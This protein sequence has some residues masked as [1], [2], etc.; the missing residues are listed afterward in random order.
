MIYDDTLYPFEISVS[1]K[2]LPNGLISIDYPKEGNNY[3]I[4]FLALAPKFDIVAS[5]LEN[6]T[7]INHIN[8]QPFIV[9]SILY[10][11]IFSKAI[12]VIDFVDY[13]KLNQI[14]VEKSS[15]NNINYNLIKL[16][17]KEWHKSVL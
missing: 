12:K 4:K 13:P 14:V 1:I 6:S 2:E 9:T 3:K 17:C 8:A 15:I 7:F 10:R 5:S 16:V 11:N